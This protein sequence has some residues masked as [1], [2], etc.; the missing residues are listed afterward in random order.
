MKHERAVMSQGSGGSGRG[1]WRVVQG[2]GVLVLLCANAALVGCEV[3]SFFDPSKTGRFHHTP[4]T[5]PILD[6]I[7]VVELESEPWGH[8][9]GVMPEDLL[10]SDLSYILAPG[11]YLTVE[12]YELNQA[13][14][15]TP[16]ARRIDATGQFRV[17]N[18]GEFMAAGRT[19]QQFEDDIIHAMRSLIDDPQVNVFVEDPRAFTYTVYGF[20]Q[21]PGQYALRQPDLR[22]IDALATIGGVPPGTENIYVIRQVL[23]TDD[24]LPGFSRDRD[25]GPST[26]A[27]RQPQDPIRPVDIDDLINQLEDAPR[28]G[29]MNTPASRMGFVDVDDLEPV[30]IPDRP[31]VDIDD[32]RSQAGQRSAPAGE[33]TFVFIEER[34]EWVRTRPRQGANGRANGA[35]AAS[36]NASPRAIVAEPD[37]ILERIIEIPYQRLA[38]GESAYNIVVRP[39]DRIYVEGPDV[40]V[41]YISGEIAR[42]GVYNMPS[43]GSGPLTLS[44][45]VA[46]AGDLAPIA[47]P[48]RVD[49]TRI[50]GPNREAT[51]RVNFAA[52]RRRTEPDII[53][54]SNDHIH[55]GTSWVATPLAIIRN[56]F[57]TTYGFGF[58]LDR[59]FGNDV[60]GPPPDARFR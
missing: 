22:L 49:I 28:P 15:W 45:L 42:P 30:R 1:S 9:T 6:R 5:L 52:I 43:V 13:R 59:N 20:I 41:V 57:R 36:A 33:D 34:N 16:V 54:K 46:A 53:I 39:N 55:I 24:V 21:N 4:T 50:I 47:I 14:T 18:L 48:E 40:G 29:M 38:K 10:P 2:A 31:I 44:R 56:G 11:D 60:F 17:P 3:D 58:L 32:L 27:P 12:I 37:L 23:L 19:V 26:P 8:I 25:A 7:D 35:A 51:V